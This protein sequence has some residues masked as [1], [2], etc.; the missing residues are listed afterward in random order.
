MEHPTGTPCHN[1]QQ[2]CM[3][4]KF[5]CLV[6]IHPT[7][8]CQSHLRKNFRTNKCWS[9]Q[10]KKTGKQSILQRWKLKTQITI[11]DE[12]IKE[13]IIITC[14]GLTVVREIKNIQKQCKNNEW[15]V[16]LNDCLRT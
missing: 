1:L 5:V 4:R 11:L 2:A 12:Y 7:D 6:W 15:L 13:E 10:C 3:G 14:I 9:D 16:Q 8:N